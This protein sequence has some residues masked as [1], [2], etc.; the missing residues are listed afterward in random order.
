M[1]A[2]NLMAGFPESTTIPAQNPTHQATKF[3][4][5]AVVCSGIVRPLARAV[6]IPRPVSSIYHPDLKHP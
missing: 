1:H 3:A 5:F 4:P 6:L 2:A